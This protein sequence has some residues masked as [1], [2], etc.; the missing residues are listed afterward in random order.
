[1]KSLGIPNGI[2]YALA[3]PSCS[4]RWARSQVKDTGQKNPERMAGA[5]EVTG[6]FPSDKEGL[7]GNKWLTRL[8]GSEGLVTKGGSY[9][10]AKVADKSKKTLI[11]VDMRKENV[12]NSKNVGFMRSCTE[13]KKTPVLKYIRKAY[14]KPKLN[15]PLDCILFL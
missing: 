12:C 11:T 4:C 10:S 14:S 5:Q 7:S 13:S 2:D 1:M 8:S 3:T 6:L 9:V 15:G